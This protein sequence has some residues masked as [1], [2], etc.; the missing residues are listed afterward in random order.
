MLVKTVDVSDAVS[1]LILHASASDVQ[2]LVL[3][4]YVVVGNFDLKS[5]NKAC[6]TEYLKHLGLNEVRILKLN[7]YPITPHF[8]QCFA[9]FA[10]AEG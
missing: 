7:V 6:K 2:V 1:G 10:A 9:L 5:S 4:C 8:R 3:S